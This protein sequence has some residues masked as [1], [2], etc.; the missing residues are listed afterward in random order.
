MS[1]D[2]RIAS[3]AEVAQAKLVLDAEVAKAKREAEEFRLM[4]EFL[5]PF[6]TDDTT[7]VRQ[8]IATMQSLLTDEIRSGGDKSTEQIVDCFLARYYPKHSSAKLRQHCLSLI[9]EQRA[10]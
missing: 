3:Q 2:D 7:T 10:V 4:M 9:R 8:A 1:H 6:F 5:A